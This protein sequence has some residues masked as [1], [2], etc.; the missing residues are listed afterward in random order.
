MFSLSEWWPGVTW[1]AT[2][3]RNN[4]ETGWELEKEKERGENGKAFFKGGWAEHF[5]VLDKHNFQS[6]IKR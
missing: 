5:W 4:G 2:G 1:W 6:M 3:I